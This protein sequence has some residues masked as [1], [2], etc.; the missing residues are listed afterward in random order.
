VLYSQKMV[1]FITTAVRTWNPTKCSIVALKSLSGFFFLFQTFEQQSST[2]HSRRA[3]R[4]HAQPSSAVS[5]LFIFTSLATSCSLVR[6][7]Y[8]SSEICSRAASAL[9]RLIVAVS[10]TDECF[11]QWVEYYCFIFWFEGRLSDILVELKRNLR[12]ELFKDRT[13]PE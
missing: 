6:H 10:E 4:Q 8:N 1:L 7:F 11:Q 12:N 3:L 13:S 9:S 2:S 5:T